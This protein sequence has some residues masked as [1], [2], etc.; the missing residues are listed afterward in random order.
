MV[1][2]PVPLDADAVN[3]KPLRFE[4]FYQ[5]FA[6]LKFAPPFER[7]IIVLQFCVGVGLV[8]ILERL[9][10]VVRTDGFNPFGLADGTCVA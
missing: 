2:S 5:T 10:D 1:Q 6:G 7:K 4:V 8:S 9:G 3:A